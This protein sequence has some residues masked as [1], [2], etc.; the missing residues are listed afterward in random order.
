MSTTVHNCRTR[1]VL[2]STLP[3]PQKL[4]FIKISFHLHDDQG[5]DLESPPFH[6]NLCACM[7]VD[8]HTYT[9]QNFHISQQIN[10]LL[11]FLLS[12]T[13]SNAVAS[14]R[15]SSSHVMLFPQDAVMTRQIK[16][17]SRQT[18]FIFS[19]FICTY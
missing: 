17:D 18:I 5:M 6:T 16:K 9:C 13:P 7:C 11:W 15:L 14:S 12:T 10:D 8:K 1:R 3:Y 4:N 2:M 19:D